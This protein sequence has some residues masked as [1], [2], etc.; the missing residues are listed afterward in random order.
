[1]NMQI[2]NFGLNLNY[3]LQSGFYLIDQEKDL[4]IPD[5]FNPFNKKIFIFFY[6]LKQ[7]GKIKIFKGDGDQ[8]RLS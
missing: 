1:M 6:K 7:Y 3:L 8:D 4:I 5:Y 2:F